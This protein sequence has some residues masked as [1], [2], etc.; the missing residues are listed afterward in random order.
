MIDENKDEGDAFFQTY[1]FKS[2]IFKVRSKVEFYG[3][4]SR[5]KLTAQTVTPVNYKDYNCHLIKN[6][7]QLTGISKR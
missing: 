5:N 1:H 4:S 3:D 6:I 2:F 7:E